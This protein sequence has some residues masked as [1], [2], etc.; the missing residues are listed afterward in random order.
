MTPNLYRAFITPG[1][2]SRDRTV[3]RYHYMSNIV[4]LPVEANFWADPKKRTTTAQTRRRAAS[5]LRS[6]YNR[7]L[8]ER[9]GFAL[10][11]RRI[12]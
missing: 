6:Q 11:Y 12:P 2:Y 4:T 1:I 5:R 10:H 7:E 8:R 3:F 9:S